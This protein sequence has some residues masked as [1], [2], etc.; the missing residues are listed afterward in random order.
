MWN[1]DSRNNG[2]NHSG[3]D[4]K[5]EHFIELCGWDIRRVNNGLDETQVG[6]IITELISQRD[7]LN[8]KTEHLSSLT[9]LAENTVTEADKFAEQLKAEAV[10]QAEAEKAAV[11]AVIEKEAQQLQGENERIRVELRG[12]VD[13]MCRELMSL[14]E[15][16]NKQL[17]SVWA[18][19]ENRLNELI[20]NRSSQTTNK[21]TEENSNSEEHVQAVK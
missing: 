10:E 7:A 19:C 9:K 18:E 2:K 20:S 16:F 3:D 6:S 12:A 13:E 14:P 11:I 8:H 15:S 1:D 5:G 4:G 17:M 21:A